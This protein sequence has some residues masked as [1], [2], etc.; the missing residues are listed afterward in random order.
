MRINRYLKERGFSTRRGADELIEAG[1]VLINGEKAKLGDRVQASDEVRLLGDGRGEDDELRYFAYY[2]PRGIISHSPQRNE[3]SI[4]DLV[5]IP[6]IFPVGR[7]DKASEGL[8]IL[9]NDG[10]VTERLL[11]PRFQH[12]KEYEVSVR[13]SLPENITTRLENGIQSDGE[14]LSARK[15]VVIGS[16]RLR[17]VL[18]EG[19]K[20]Q[21]RRML[22]YLSLTVETLRR[23]RIMHLTLGTMK[24]GEKRKLVGQEKRKFLSVLEI[25]DER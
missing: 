22:D 6:N 10:R 4:A 19:K 3:K 18:T 9:T 20:H 13:E 17:I 23:V 7:L 1:L 14:H 25:I 15:V 21:I 11:H 2:K 24:P 12:E 5:R 8:M 16:R